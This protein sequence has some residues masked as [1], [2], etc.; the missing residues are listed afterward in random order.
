MEA[1]EDRFML[2]S[3]SFSTGSETVNESAGTFSIPVTLSGTR[4]QTVSTFA[5]G[6][7]VSRRP[8]LRRRRQPLRRQLRAGS[9]VSEVTPAGV[10]STFASGF[11]DPDGLA[12]DAAGNLYVANYGNNTVSEVTPAGVVSTFASGFNEPDGLAFDAPATS[13]SPTTAATR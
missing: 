13:T 5:S 4:T 10:V 6:F 8:G 3:V 11:D 9:T 7:D 12:F 2:S 1:L